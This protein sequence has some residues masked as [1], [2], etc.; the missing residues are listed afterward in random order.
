MIGFLRKSARSRD[1]EQIPEV[2]GS[3]QNQDGIIYVKAV[4]PA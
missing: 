3:L 4:R 2:E 1:A